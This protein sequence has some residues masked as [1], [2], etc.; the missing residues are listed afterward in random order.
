MNTEKWGSHMWIPLHVITFNAPSIIPTEYAKNYTDFFRILGVMLPCKYCRESYCFFYKNL[1]IEEYLEDRMGLT[2]WL[3]AIHTLVSIKLK[4]KYLPTFNEIVYKY[5]EMRASSNPDYMKKETID[6]FII[7][8]Q[9]K[10]AKKTFDYMHVIISK[11]NKIEWD[12]SKL[13]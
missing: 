3:Y 2:Y 10:Y 4:K 7:S 8:A 11:L 5:E 6:K 9:Q 12:F 1:P 13:A